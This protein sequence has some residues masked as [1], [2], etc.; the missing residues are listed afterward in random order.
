M[1]K[2]AICAEIGVYKGEY[3]QKILQITQPLKLHLIDPWQYQEDKMYQKACYGQLSGGQLLLEQK[4]E[5]VVNQ[6]A[7][8]I[9]LG[10]VVIHREYSNE[11][12]SQFEDNYFDW[13][14]IDGN[15]LYEFVKQDLELYYDKVKKGGFITGDDYGKGGWWQGGVTKA[16]NEFIAQGGV[17]LVKISGDQFILKK[18]G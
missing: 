10:Q 6:F 4:Y 2:K 7:K 12:Y 15:H 17:K 9:N 13:I 5:N 16:V 8:E 14:Y 3:S 1:Q 18:Q 11:I